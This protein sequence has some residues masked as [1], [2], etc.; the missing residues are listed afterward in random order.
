[1]KSIL[2]A[3]AVLLAIGGCG[4]DSSVT[5]PV[6][7]VDYWSANPLLP[8]AAG[9]R[10]W[11]I[12]TPS[13]MRPVNPPSEQA[14]AAEASLVL[15]RTLA[16][17]QEQETEILAWGAGVCARW[18]ALHRRL[19][20]RTA[21]NPPRAARGLALV[22][23][24][25][26]DA[27][28]AAW[29]A[30]YTFNRARP[31]QYQPSIEV[32]GGS[33]QTPSYIAERTA[34]SVAAA[35]VLTYLFPAFAETCAELQAS[36]IQADMM[37][38]HHFQSDIDAAVV[39]GT[40]VA[41]AAIARGRGDGSDNLYSG[42]IPSGPGMWVPTPPAFVPQPLEPVAGQWQTWVLSSGADIRPPAPPAYGSDEFDVQV[43]EV[44]RA[45][46]SLTADR[47][48]IATRWADGPG[49]QTPAGHWNEIAVGLA[50]AA[51]MSEPEVARMLATLGVA[52]ADA[53]IACWDCKFA[54]W[55]VRP[56]TEIRARF[57]PQ[58]TPP[59][60]TPP[61]PAYPSGHSATSGA[62]SLV[63]VTFFPASATTIMNQAVD[64]M[65]SRLY[66]GIHYPVD[67]TCGL[68]LGIAIATRLTAQDLGD[69]AVLMESACEFLRRGIVGSTADQRG[70]AAFA[71]FPGG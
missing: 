25:M 34:I 48:A 44:W 64:A 29:D 63:L 8:E 16:R 70:L 40:T 55:C 43:D 27:V 33:S 21:T 36:A 2:P 5:A 39:L 13:A 17:T 41:G 10:T 18:N 65:N 20:A 38:G 30:K 14:T 52:Q 54:Y 51:G 59:L 22:G 3:L 7:P 53:F 71:P 49:T 9:W 61:F 12:D 19:I 4:E 47:L 31:V 60:V 46:Q 56:V 1:M 37:S 67:N 35:S 11:L 69:K 15:E 42:S 62:A 58:W 24:A 68:T 57:D 66:G 28:V 50:T 45:N 32:F 6:D 23:T 26:N